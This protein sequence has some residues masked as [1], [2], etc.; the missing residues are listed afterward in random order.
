MRK[1]PDKMFTTVYIRDRP[2]ANFSNIALAKFSGLS[3]EQISQQ[4]DI[5]I[6]TLS[7]FYNRWCRRFAPLLKTELKKHF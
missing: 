1:D 5:P 6:P 2:D 7:S 4:L 3:W